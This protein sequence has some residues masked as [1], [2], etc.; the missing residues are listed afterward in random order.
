MKK[1]EINLL[2]IIL[3]E[4]IILLFFF[5]ESLLNILLA[6]TIN[7]FFLPLIKRIKKKKIMDIFLLIISIIIIILLL[8]TIT[9]FIIHNILKQYPSII[10]ILTVII[11]SYL[12]SQHGFHP[13]IKSL[14]ICFYFFLII[15]IISFLLLLPNI[16][17]ANF[18]HQLLNQLAINQ[19]LF[20]IT[21]SFFFLNIIINYLTNNLPNKN[22]FALSI[23]N[24]LIIKILSLSILGQTLVNLYQYPY[25]N[26]F[27]RIKYFDFIER[28]EGILSF[29]YLFSFIF[30][31]SFFFLFIKTIIKKTR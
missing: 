24:P 16:D 30:L 9:N 22:F 1:I 19:N 11:I 15:K 14:E 29:E 3:F 31:I 27:K 6:G 13:F 17:F 26:I 8:S 20:L 21:V 4:G 5:H 12:L 18:N 28:M 7:L 25:V 23:V 10:I 2:S